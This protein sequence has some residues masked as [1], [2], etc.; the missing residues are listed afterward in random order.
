VPLEV[1]RRSV[2]AASTA[3]QEPR[4]RA[5]A[6]STPAPASHASKARKCSGDSDRH[7][8]VPEGLEQIAA[9]PAG[10]FPVV[11]VEM[12][13]VVTRAGDGNPDRGGHKGSWAEPL[14]RRTG[15]RSVANAGQFRRVELSSG[16]IF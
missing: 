8:V 12:G 11:V 6:T 16:G 1:N 14:F 5:A 3:S 7:A 15:S 2:A 13:D 9:C 4:A 10:Q